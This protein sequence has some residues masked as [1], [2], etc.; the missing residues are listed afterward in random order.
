MKKSLFTLILISLFL[1]SCTSYKTIPL[2]GNYLDKPYVIESEKNFN[3]VWSNIIDLFATNGISIK[4]LDKDSGLIVAEKTSFINN[5]T[6]ENKEG[7]LENPNAY[8]IVN[9]VKGDALLD[10]SII[11]VEIFGEWNVRI[12]ETVDNKTS[13]NINL[14]SLEAWGINYNSRY[15]F[16]IKST[17]VYENLIA[18]FI[19]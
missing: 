1:T 12:K 17:G 3:Q 4:L 16:L 2:K 13:I 7:L 11:P 5:Y 15:F 6:Y 14:N 18:E 8:V 9:K 10:R 19:K